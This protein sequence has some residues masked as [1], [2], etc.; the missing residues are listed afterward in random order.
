MLDRVLAALEQHID[1]VDVASTRAALGTTITT[2]IL[3]LTADE[4][5]IVSM[6]VGIVG[7]VATVAFNI[8]FKWRFRRGND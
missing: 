2:T 6:I 5:G 3:G 4:W 1:L 8:W 7:T